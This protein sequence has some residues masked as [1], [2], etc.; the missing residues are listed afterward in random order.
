[1]KNKRKIIKITAII[2]VLFIGILVA[3]PF[4]FKGKIIDLIK[5]NLNNNLNARVDFQEA[6][7]SIFRG[8]PNATVN[9]KNTVIINNSPFAND[10][11]FY[12]EEIELRMGIGELF[13][14]ASEVIRVQHFS[15]DNT[16]LKLF[17]N[18]Q[19]AANYDIAKKEEAASASTETKNSN[20]EFSVDGYEINNATVY[21]EDMGTGIVLKIDSLQHTGEGDLSL[22]KSELATFSSA[23]VSFEM[24]SINYLNRNPVKLDALIG[25]DLKESTYSFLKNEAI[26]NQLPLVFDGF[27]KLNEDHQLVSISFKTPSSDFKNFLAVIPETYAKNIDQVQ[28][29]G[30]FEVDGKFEG[31]VDDVHIPEFTISLQSDN[32]KFKYPQ[33]PKS[34]ENIKIKTLIANETGLPKDTYIN[35]DQLSFK[36]DDDVFNA[37][38]RFSNL[39]E[40]PY[41]NAH[42]DGRLNLGNLSN[43]YPIETQVPLSGILD[44]N[45]TTSFDMNTIEKGAY[46]KT[47]NEGTLVLTGF[48][49]ESEELAKPIKINKADL[50][51]NPQTVTLNS[52][53]ALTGNT[54]IRANG[55]ISNLLGYLFNNET[56]KGKFNMRSNTFAVND[57][58][59]KEQSDEE[60]KNNEAQKRKE[61]QAKPEIKIPSFLDCT[62]EATAETVLYDNI[63]LKDVSGTLLIADE[64]AI[65]KN[66]NSSVFDGALALNGSVSTKSETPVF[67][68]NL[69]IN[70]FNIASSFK[71][72]ELFKALAPLADAIQGK[73]NATLSLSGNLTDDFTPD[74][75]S[76]SGN[77]LAEFLS[78]KINPENSKVLSLVNNQLNFIDLS[79]LD[80]EDLKTSLSFED[81]KVKLA[82]F[83]FNYKDIAITVAGSHGFD[84]SMQ[85]GVQFNVP[86]KY[87]GKDAAELIA[88][89]NDQEAGE[90]KVPVNASLTGSFSNP[91][92]STDLKQ[93]VTNL[94]KELAARQ[95][96]KLVG[97]GKDAVKD[98]LGGLLGKEKDTVTND[99][100]KKSDPV[101][102][103][104]GS[105]IK[106]LF[107]KKE[108]K[109]D[110]VR[111]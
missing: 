51:F 9:L 52:L 69:D 79:K 2:L 8:F 49:Y 31:K 1:M 109:K 15:V 53:D 4:I 46:E 39:I 59:V 37:N 27:V 86:A 77:A 70:A 28:T 50:T 106:G 107:G 11:L 14:D 87:L 10:T 101:K 43:A 75:S 30:K 24:D 29:E 55:T 47:R 102:D 38:A 19:G 13:K 7:L 81:G 99:T 96:D 74:L 16:R 93:A 80:L 54:D 42:I 45:V 100:V 103:A 64:K 98:A 40:N 104:A 76:V 95:K 44:A 5:Q 71:Q 21:Y 33:L 84:R 105:L 3:V 89:L 6:D 60:G 58:M 111:N 63:T 83:D 57:F 94:T 85:Y 91:S 72:L 108:R 68:M 48:N 62:I 26:V 88:R 61:D 92:I 97:K 32:A 56:F 17:I 82:P 66:L 67:D 90:V 23:L 36:I 65:L 73:L 41:I 12:A 18:E 35:V 25:I 110:T 22:E 78:S 20:F 34:V